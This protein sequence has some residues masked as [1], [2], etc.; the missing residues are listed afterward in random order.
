MSDEDLRGYDEAQER[1]RNT[2]TVGSTR[3][4]LEDMMKEFRKHTPTCKQLAIL[5]FGVA[6]TD[7]GVSW[8]V[9]IRAP[10][11]LVAHLRLFPRSIPLRVPDEGKGTLSC[12]P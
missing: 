5:S 4:I 6:A 11:L 2:C 1:Y 10:D 12:T 9:Q 7:P 8:L 3:A